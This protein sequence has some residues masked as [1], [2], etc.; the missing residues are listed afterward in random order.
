MKHYTKCPCGRNIDEIIKERI[1]QKRVCH[2]HKAAQR[3]LKLG[4]YGSQYVFDCHKISRDMRKKEGGRAEGSLEPGDIIC[5]YKYILFSSEEAASSFY[6]ESTYDV[7]Q[8]LIIS[9]KVEDSTSIWLVRF[10]DTI[11]AL[12]I[13]DISGFINHETLEMM[14]GALSDSIG[15]ETTILSIHN[16]ERVASRSKYNCNPFC[17]LLFKMKITEECCTKH[18]I[19]V[20]ALIGSKPYD[21]IKQEPQIYSIDKWCGFVQIAIPILVNNRWIGT[22]VSGGLWNKD[23]KFEDFLKNLEKDTTIYKKFRQEIFSIKTENWPLKNV[24]HIGDTYEERI[25]NLKKVFNN[26]ETSER[27]NPN[28]LD[29]YKCNAR[30]SVLN[31]Q[32]ILEERYAAIRQ[33]KNEYWL[34]RLV[35]D[36][37]KHKTNQDN[38]WKDVYQKFI[39]RMAEYGQFKESYFLVNYKDAKTFPEYKKTF[40]IYS[41]AQSNT[42]IKLPDYYNIEQKFFTEPI[43]IYHIT[44]SNDNPEIQPEDEREY[45]LSKDILKQL[46]YEAGKLPDHCIVMPLVLSKEDERYGIV[47]FAGRKHKKHEFVDAISV[48]IRALLLGFRRNFLDRIK[49]SYEEIKKQESY[50]AQKSFLAFLNH[51]IAITLSYW[52]GSLQWIVKEIQQKFGITQTKKYNLRLVDQ[53]LQAFQLNKLV[54]D[55][56]LLNILNEGK[57]NIKREKVDLWELIKTA[58]HLYAGNKSRKELSFNF[59]DN[60]KIFVSVDRAYMER[61]LGNIVRNAIQYAY[62]DTSISFRRFDTVDSINITVTNHGIPVEKE[63]EEKIFDRGFRSPNAIDHCTGTGY[64]LWLSRQILR[65][66][67]V[68]FDL[69]YKRSPDSGNES[70]FVIKIPKRYV[71]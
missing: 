12:F 30:K 50:E 8:R 31:I 6:K 52:N 37:E 11:E 45:T 64:G 35:L 28:K 33:M 48:Y 60:L 2:D 53:R 56:A 23:F 38:L 1:G 29:E 39:L 63:Y 25:E 20:K 13:N 10:I 70:T 27:F 54:G 22:A 59:G 68:G 51:E 7:G 14:A 32:E 55:L 42:D 65:A 58:T 67:G 47:I 5:D 41:K 36:W 24:S 69:F 17:Q 43:K 16:G 18:S 62:N 40:T 19:D 34:Q 9:F 46:N 26:V 61:V 21:L 71:I 3:D 44:E 15:I 57:L 4:L 66:H 49:I